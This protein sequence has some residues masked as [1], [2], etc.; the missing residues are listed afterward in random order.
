MS[1]NYEQRTQLIEALEWHLDHGADALLSD[2]AIDCTILPEMPKKLPQKT[3]EKPTENPSSFTAG[4]RDSLVQQDLQQ[5]SNDGAGLMGAA[6][7]IVDSGKIA[8]SC[9]SLEALQEAIAG[10][11]GLSIRKTATNMVFAD[12]NSKSAVMVIGDVP[13]AQDDIGAL[14]FIGANGVLLDRILASIGL[15][16]KAEDHMRAVYMTNLLNW[17]PPGN[18]TPT[19]AEIDISLPFLE[20]HIALVQPKALILWGGL[21]AKAL[22]RRSESISKLRGSLHEY[23]SIPAMV[24]YHPS[25]LISTPARKRAVWEDMLMFQEKSGLFPSAD[26]A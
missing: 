14:P 19:Q 13:D 12:G 18:R 5:N 4:L 24:T 15:D 2:V 9:M 7:A 10:F 16:R 1:Q 25:Y 26:N 3:I 22:L 21:P 20:R 8:A 23:Q 6:Q 17:R 11:E